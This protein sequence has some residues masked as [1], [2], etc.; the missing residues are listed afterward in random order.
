MSVLIGQAV[1]DVLFYREREKRG[2]TVR[3]FIRDADNMNMQRAFLNT[4]ARLITLNFSA[5]RKA[6]RFMRF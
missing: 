2:N 6:R 1:C 3:L 4:F 5:R